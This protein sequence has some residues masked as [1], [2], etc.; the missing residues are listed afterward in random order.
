MPWVKGQQILIRVAGA[1]D[2]KAS[3]HPY[4]VRR[5]FEIHLAETPWTTEEIPLPSEYDRN[6]IWDHLRTL[7]PLSEVSQFKIGC[8]H[9]GITP[10]DPWPIGVIQAYP[11]IF[12]VTWQVENPAG[13]PV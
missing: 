1:I 4:H 11:Q 12:P 6:Q 10:L 13:P 9:I 3:K 5:T 8:N 2:Y 7:H